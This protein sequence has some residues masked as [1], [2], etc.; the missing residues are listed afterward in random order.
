MPL[1]SWPWRA[2]RS[3]LRAAGGSSGVPWVAPP[4]ARCCGAPFL[5]PAA[6]FFSRPTA[7]REGTRKCVHK[8]PADPLRLSRSHLRPPPLHRRNRHARGWGIVR[9]CWPAR[10]GGFVLDRLRRSVALRPSRAVAFCCGCYWWSA[11]LWRPRW[12]CSGRE[13]GV[14]DVASRCIGVGSTAAR[15]PS[16]LVCEPDDF[17]PALFFS[18][19][20]CHHGRHGGQSTDS[21]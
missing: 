2:I 16:R 4:A 9:V 6:P 17:A 15:S 8:Q 13:R 12:D 7:P 1:G 20:L 11:R 3:I 10:R 14:A 5:R 21:R 18:L 19:R